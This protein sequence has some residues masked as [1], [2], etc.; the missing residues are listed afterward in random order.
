LRGALFV[1]FCYYI[2]L[3][4]FEQFPALH[5]FVYFALVILDFFQVSLAKKQQVCG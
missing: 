5:A 2:A 1:V 3:D 4:I